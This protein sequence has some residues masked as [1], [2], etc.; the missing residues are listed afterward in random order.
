MNGLC[1]F[2]ASFFAFLLVVASLTGVG[3]FRF[4]VLFGTAGFGLVVVNL[5]LEFAT[6]MESDSMPVV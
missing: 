3:A 2:F 4:L 5:S 1:H 6:I